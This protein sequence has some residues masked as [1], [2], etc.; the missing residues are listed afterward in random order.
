MA[1]SSLEEFFARYVRGREELDFQKAFAAVGL[2]LDRGLRDSAGKPVE[3]VYLGA[4]VAE[5]GDRVIVR[6]VY[7][8]SAAY[9][10][11]LNTGDQIIALNNM[12]VDKD[13]FDARVAERKP[14]DLINL[15]IFRFDDLSTLL[16]KLGGRTDGTY[17]I[18]PAESPT[19]QQ[20]QIYRSWLGA[21]TS[22]A[23]A[24]E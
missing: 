11:G 12:R 16:I 15:T 24:E 5:E 1:G 19:E 20:R 14:G 13:F 17:R 21:N 7:A 8:G 23:R 2:R 22:E 6:R 18:V 9:E 10:Q 4:D 3:R